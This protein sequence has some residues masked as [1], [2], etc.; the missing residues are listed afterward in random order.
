[1]MRGATCNSSFGTG[2]EIEV[3]LLVV[4]ERDA[5]RYKAHRHVVTFS[6]YIFKLHFACKRFKV[7]KLV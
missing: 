6:S 4:R 5:L 7:P 3:V 2:V 1:M